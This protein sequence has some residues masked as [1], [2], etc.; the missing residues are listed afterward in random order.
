MLELSDGNV[1]LLLGDAELAALQRAVDGLTAQDGISCVLLIDT[2]GK[3]VTVSGHAGQ[4]DTATIAALAAGD[5]AT[6]R[7]LARRVGEKDFSLV[8]QRDH[9]L[10]AYLHA[11]SEEALLV[12]LFTEGTPL[13]GVRQAV[14]QAQMAVKKTLLMTRRTVTSADEVREM[15]AERDADGKTK[16]PDPAAPPPADT[17][18]PSAD[19]VRRFWRIKALAED[20]VRIEVGRACP[21][22]WR[23]SRER[24]AVATRLLAENKREECLAL[25]TEVEGLLRRAYEK[26]LAIGQEGGKEW[27]MVGLMQDLVEPSTALFRNRLGEPGLGLLPNV[28]REIMERHRTLLGEAVHGTIQPA[29]LDAIARLPKDQRHMAILRAFL[30]LLLSRLWVTR[31][32]FGEDEAETLVEAWERII[33]ERGEEIT[34]LGMRPALRYLLEE[35]ERRWPAAAAAKAA[36]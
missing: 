35:I 24:L 32:L 16:A 13:G 9:Q 6:T 4:L 3:I 15:L 18:P 30:D 21:T 36:V 1:N 10:N 27:S 14:K 20:C 5:Y 28:D 17:A 19:V 29:A 22:E 34:R 2:A 11:V 12:V 8:F 33:E 23:V 26:A 25:L 31:K 7:A